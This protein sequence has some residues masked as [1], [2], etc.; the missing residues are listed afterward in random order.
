MPTRFHSAIISFFMNYNN[1]FFKKNK[2]IN[3]IMPLNFNNNSKIAFYYLT[4]PPIY[5][6][7]Q[8][9]IIKRKE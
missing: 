8:E 7:Y 5:F 2:G 4:N 6:L 3:C 9:L 1:S